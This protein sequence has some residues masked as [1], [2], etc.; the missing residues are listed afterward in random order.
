[1]A[2]EH[3]DE[4]KLKELEDDARTEVEAG[5]KFALDASFPDPSEATEDVYA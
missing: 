1:M 5:V 3:I 2:I 4:D